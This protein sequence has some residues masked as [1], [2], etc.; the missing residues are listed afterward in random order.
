LAA[1]PVVAPGVAE[2]HAE[3]ASVDSKT[4]NVI[5]RFMLP[6]QKLGNPVKKL[7]MPVYL[8]D[9]MLHSAIARY[10]E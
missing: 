2:L 1:R 7:T 8:N 5:H 9:R 6:P 3:S 4:A 10:V